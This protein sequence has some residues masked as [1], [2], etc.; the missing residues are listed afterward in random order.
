[1]VVPGRLTILFLMAL[2]VGLAPGRLEA[3]ESMADG[4]AG[5]RGIALKTYLLKTK[6]WTITEYTEF[7]PTSRTVD[8]GAGGLGLNLSY[9]L[10]PNFA[11]FAAADVSL[12]GGLEFFLTR[13]LSFGVGVQ[14]IRALGDGVQEN[15]PVPSIGLEPTRVTLDT[16]LKRRR[17][18][19][20]W[21]PGRRWE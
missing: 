11:I 9:A 10:H 18:G 16:T 2:P 3:Q 8:A 5:F 17:Y 14:A 21:Y 7:G 19:F 4:S 20:H 12:D 13:R 15:D 6:P 1:M